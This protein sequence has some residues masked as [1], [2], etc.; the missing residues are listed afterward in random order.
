MNI[1]TRLLW[2]FAKFFHKPTY[3]K[4]KAN[5]LRTCFYLFLNYLQFFWI[6]F[7]WGF[8]FAFL[9]ILLISQIFLFLES[10]RI[11]FLTHSLSPCLFIS[12]LVYLLTP[13][14]CKGNWQWTLS[15][16]YIFVPYLCYILKTISFSLFLSRKHAIES[17]QCCLRK[18]KNLLSCAKHFFYKY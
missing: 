11:S 4:K 18:M 2:Q 14:L 16:W 7:L 1:S 17:Q 5:I 9:F 3:V 15:P 12:C 6:H 8:S 13:P 10:S